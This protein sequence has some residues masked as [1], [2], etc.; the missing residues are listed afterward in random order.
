MP[1]GILRLAQL[2]HTVAPP[3]ID[4]ADFSVSQQGGAVFCLSAELSA[5]LSAALPYPVQYNE[6]ILNVSLVATHSLPEKRNQTLFSSW[7]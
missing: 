6:P 5:E 1:L 3:Y 2:L 7:E 4:S